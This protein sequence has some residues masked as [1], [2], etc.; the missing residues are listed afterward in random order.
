MRFL[1]MTGYYYKFWCN[2]STLTKGGRDV[3]VVSHWY[4]DVRKKAR[5]NVVCICKQTECFLKTGCHKNRCK[6]QT[7]LDLVKSF[8]M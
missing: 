4:S 8:S 2:L 3:S 6:K 7:G 5:T 1:G